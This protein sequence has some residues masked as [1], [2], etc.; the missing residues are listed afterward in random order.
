MD[1]QACMDKCAEIDAWRP[2]KK[3]FNSAFVFLKPA[4]VTDKMK[5]LVKSTFE[6]KNI[7][8]LK[9]GS[10]EAADIDKKQLVDK[11]YYAIA[12]KATLLTP[13]KLSVPK[14]KFKDA[15]GLEWDD[16][17]KDGKAINAKEACEKFECDA[18]ELDKMWGAAKKEKNLVKLGGGFY[19][20][21]ITKEGKG[22]YYV[23][24]GFFMTMRA[25][26]VKEGAS[27]YYFAVEWETKDLSW[28]DF[29]GKVLGPTD[30]ADAPKD[31]LR[32][33]ALADWKN[34]GL[35]SEPNTGENCVH[36]SASPFEG[37]AERMNWLGY[38]ADRDKFGRDLLNAGVR[39]KT[40]KDWTLDPVVQYG[41]KMS[42]T[43]KSIWDTLEDMDSPEC[44]AKCAEIDAWRP[45]KKPKFNKVGKI[46]PDQ[47]GVNLLLKCVKAPEDKDVLCGDETGTIMLS[48][49]SDA[50]L[51]LC[52]AGAM[53]RVQNAN[54][55]MVKGFI[56]LIIDKWCIL[57][58]A[59]SVDFETVDETSKNNISA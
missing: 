54:V 53:L 16:V 33:G 42:P 57:K 18:D 6:A 50:Q 36:A 21:K 43:S 38:R 47:K 55:R 13:D 5:E 26:Y 37:L 8:V 34:L 9:E 35:A 48:V 23:F 58:A 41:D 49:S 24:N 17:L 2:P 27:I 52:K 32:G 39:P 31:S 51:A 15:F 20:G 40:I 29:R 30:P 22:T 56:R 1:A 59:E 7:K 12:S 28:A 46:N 19:C 45:L 25:G 44:I 10:I 3:V 11:H 4:A 14:D